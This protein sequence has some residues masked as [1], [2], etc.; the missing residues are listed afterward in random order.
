M[1]S[2]FRVLS[3]QGLK[4]NNFSYARG[5]VRVR[6]Y[7]YNNKLS[8]ARRSLRSALLAGVNNKKQQL[9]YKEVCLECLAHNRAIVK[10]CKNDYLVNVRLAAQPAGCFVERMRCFIYLGAFLVVSGLEK[11]VR[12]VSGPGHKYQKRIAKKYQKVKKR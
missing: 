8:R 3:T 4:W 1:K 9:L 5:C 10:H 12:C 11:G 7:N 6:Y 2:V